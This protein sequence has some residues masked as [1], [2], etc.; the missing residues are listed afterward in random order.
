MMI[1]ELPMK[2]S[3]VTISFNQRQYLEEALNSVLQQDYPA[4]EYIVV[5]PGSSDGSRE[6]IET[7]AS[8]LERVIFEPD[9]GAADGLNKGFAHASGEIF[10]FLNSDDVLL[11]GALRS[12]SVAF[13]QNPDCDIVMG[14]GFTIEGRGKRIRRIRAA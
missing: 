7:Y 2:F 14:N 8:R 12:V 5:D 9:R 11:P 3:N 13:E 10:G 6:L 4:I 1:D